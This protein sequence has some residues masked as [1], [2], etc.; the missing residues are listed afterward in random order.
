MKKKIVMLT[1]VHNATDDRIFYKQARS[2]SQ[3]GYEVVIIGQHPEDTV[4][5]GVKIVAL[6]KPKNRLRRILFST[7]TVFKLALK[8]KAN[9]YHFHDPELIPIGIILKLLKKKVIYDVHEDYSEQILSKNYIS[10]WCRKFIS[11]LFN[12]LEKLFCCFFDGIV[13]A[14]DYLKTKFKHSLKI[15]ARN[16]PIIG[17][18]IEKNDLS[19]EKDEKTVVIYAGGLTKI[20]GITEIVKAFE[21]IKT[22]N[23]ELWLFGEFY[24]EDYREEIKK[25][26][27]FE[28]TKWKGMVS[29]EEIFSYY[30]KADI[31]IVCLS[32]IP[33]YIKATP[34]KLFEY[35]LSGLA[36]IAS[37][38]PLWKEIVEGNRCGITVDPL[39]PEEIAHAI[40]YLA[41]KP[42]L[43]RQMGENGKRAVFEK[44]NWENESKKLV[45]LYKEILT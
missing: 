21:L 28:R 9:L 25:T 3:A 33:N 36:V 19:I 17:K 24:P 12:A 39:N 11:F 44:Y 13:I 32:P 43:R 30:K 18:K 2:L 10:S 29:F 27:G 26:K 23:V 4:I 34:N 14:H 20:R 16:Y 38:F 15:S 6:K 7:I 45:N 37:N 31:G 41:N 35:M 8:E 22:D 42:E 1:S 40:E 5:E